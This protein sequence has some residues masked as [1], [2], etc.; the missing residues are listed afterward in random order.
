[1]VRTMHVSRR[2]ADL[3]FR[4]MQGESINACIVRHK[5][6]QA[7]RLLKS[8]NLSIVRIADLAG[9]RDAKYLMRLFRNRHGVSMNVWRNTHLGKGSQAKAP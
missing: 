9:F 8:G 4:Q 3:R 7:E 5:L 2:L 1:M 6:E